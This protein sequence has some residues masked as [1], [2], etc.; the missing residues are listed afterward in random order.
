[1]PLSLLAWR[2]RSDPLLLLALLFMLRCVLDP[3]NTAYYALPAI[4]ALVTWEAWRTERPPLFALALTMAT[5]ATWQWVVPAASADVEALVYLAWSLPLR[6]PAGVAALRAGAARDAGAQPRRPRERL[7]HDAVALGQAQERGELVLARV[8][9]E[10][11]VQPHVLEADRRLLVDAER[12]AEVEVA[13]GAD[14]AAAHVD[15]ERGGD[16]PERHARAGGERLEQHVAGAQL[17]AVAAARGMQPRLGE[18]TAGVD[19]CS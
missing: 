15:A 7:E 3:W 19:A 13:L 17:R 16:R 9:V 4:I 5:W 1:M 18:R 12:A 14:R 10:L 6:R 2:R 8:G 11:E